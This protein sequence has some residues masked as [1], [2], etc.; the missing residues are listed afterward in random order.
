M[1]GFVSTTLAAG[2]RAGRPGASPSWCGSGAPA[3]PAP[4]P[5]APPVGPARAPS[6]GRGRGPRRGLGQEGLEDRQVVAEGLAGRGRRHDD[7]QCPWR[8][9]RAP[10]PD[11][12]RGP[13]PRA[14]AGRRRDGGRRRRRERDRA[15][16][17]GT[18]EAPS[19]LHRPLT[20]R[21]IRLG[22]VDARFPGPAISA[23]ILGV[24]RERCQRSGR[25]SMGRSRWRR[26][27]VR[28]PRVVPHALPPLLWMASSRSARRA[29]WPATDGPVVPRSSAPSPWAGPATTPRPRFAL[30]KLGP[31]GRVRHSRRPVAPGVPPRGPAP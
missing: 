24:A 14:P 16:R 19:R 6:W 30:R 20:R 10:R 1:S 23:V 8:G 15:A 12:C 31:S 17:A 2:R 26:L 4:A 28:R 11:A 13:R 21:S 9:A 27:P 29:S 7:Q 5:P 18:G 3:A 22:E 25:G